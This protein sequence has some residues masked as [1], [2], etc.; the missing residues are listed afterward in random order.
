MHD[1]YC[2]C[3]EQALSIARL[4]SGTTRPAH[5]STCTSTVTRPV[6]ISAHTSKFTSTLTSTSPAYINIVGTRS[7]PDSISHRA[8][9]WL[10]TQFL[11]QDEVKPSSAGW[12]RSVEV[13]VNTKTSTTTDATETSIISV[14]VSFSLPSPKPVTPHTHKISVQHPSTPLPTTTETEPVGDDED[15][16]NEERNENL[17]GGGS[18]DEHAFMPSVSV[19]APNNCPPRDM[20]PRTSP[21]ASSTPRSGGATFEID[22][23][24]TTETT[25]LPFYVHEGLT[26]INDVD[27]PTL[28][29]VS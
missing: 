13:V 12:P 4:A 21:H 10:Y 24:T 27:Q 2:T 22:R 25:E 18:G 1:P 28:R 5:L 3:H 26:I 8:D 6:P 29:G 15:F 7:R 20:K 14:E 9:D 11:R 16:D 23:T 17:S 19:S